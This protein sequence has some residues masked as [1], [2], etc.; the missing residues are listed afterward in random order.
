MP[1]EHADLNMLTMAKAL[2]YTQPHRKRNLPAPELI[3]QQRV[4][5]LQIGFAAIPAAGLE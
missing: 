5:S 3:E 1:T 4:G 2:F